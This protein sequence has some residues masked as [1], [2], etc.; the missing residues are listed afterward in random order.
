MLPPTPN[1]EQYRI[2]FDWNSATA[3]R[4]ISVEGKKAVVENSIG[5]LKTVHGNFILKPGSKYYWE[6]KFNHGN[7]AVIG[8]A[9]NPFPTMSE[10]V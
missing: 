4:E 10:S 5:E 2:R 3:H 9:P 7:Q 6:V 1:F 8:I